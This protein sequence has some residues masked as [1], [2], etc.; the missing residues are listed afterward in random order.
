[1]RRTRKTVHTP[2][3]S[4][5]WVYVIQAWPDGIS[6]RLPII[7]IP[8]GPGGNGNRPGFAFLLSMILVF[9]QSTATRHSKRKMGPGTDCKPIV[10]SG[11]KGMIEVLAVWLMRHAYNTMAILL[12][13]RKEEVARMDWNRKCGS[14]PPMSLGIWCQRRHCNMW[15]QCRP[16]FTLEWRSL[17]KFGAYVNNLLSQN[18]KVSF[19]NKKWD[20]LVP[21]PLCSL[22][23]QNGAKSDKEKMTALP[24]FLTMLRCTICISQD[25]K[26]KKVCQA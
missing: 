22:I 8:F 7:G 3:C 25:S 12:V 24:L 14:I 17:S 26:I 20:L 23:P 15:W 1:V 9:L 21:Y 5:H 2:Y 19:L 11:K 6:R 18:K 13:E 10:R 4:L 16:A